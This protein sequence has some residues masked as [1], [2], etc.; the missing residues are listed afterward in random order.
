M[1]CLY[2]RKEVSFK[3]SVC[4][5]CH[6][7]INASSKVIKCDSCGKYL[8][9]SAESCPSCGAV[10]KA[11]RTHLQMP[12]KIAAFLIFCSL[13]G[14]FLLGGGYWKHRGYDAGYSSG[15]SAGEAVVSE[16]ARQAIYDE[17]YSAGQSNSV[18]VLGYEDGYAVGLEAGEK[19][20]YQKGYAD[21]LDA[22]YI[23]GSLQS[24]TSSEPSTAYVPVA[25]ANSEPAQENPVE[26]IVYITR[27]G[28]KYHTSGCRYLRKSKIEI[29]LSNAKAQGY[30]P[31]SVCHPPR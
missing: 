5:H 9:S 21:G 13:I 19:F 2:C 26:T 1:W 8:L 30:T 10:K 22:G 11:N 7:P 14:G 20:G 16:S 17:G 12:G 28:S 31:C 15:Y 27:T 24:S 18:P 23:S 6:R 4:P 25:R 29:S 3:D